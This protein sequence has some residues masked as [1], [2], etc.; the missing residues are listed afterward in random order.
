MVELFLFDINSRD[1]DVLPRRASRRVGLRH[2]PPPG[3][4]GQ[5]VSATRS[6][7]PPR[8]SRIL[9]L[10][11]DHH[12][13]GPHDGAHADAKPSPAHYDLEP[14]HDLLWRW[15]VRGQQQEAPGRLGRSSSSWQGECPMCITSLRKEEHITAYD[16]VKA[17]RFQ[18]QPDARLQGPRPGR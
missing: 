14:P 16:P 15:S 7:D 6:F 17:R 3:G 2:L 12:V 18:P 4:G 13:P 10:S 9:R 5:R 11:R 1:D 8:S